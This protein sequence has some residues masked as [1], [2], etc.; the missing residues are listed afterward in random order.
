[1]S[2]CHLKV[3]KTR[4]IYKVHPP[5]LPPIAAP[6]I[7]TNAFLGRRHIHIITVIQHHQLAITEERF[8]WIVVR[9]ALGQAHPMQPQ[10]VP[11]PPGLTRLAWMSRGLIQG[12]PYLLVGIPTTHLA[13]E[14]TDILRTFAR[15]VRPTTAATA[16]VVDQ[17]QIE[18]PA[19]CLRRG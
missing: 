19:C 7:G 10:C 17:E 4:Q 18:S 14:L 13:H 15:K 1:M 9:A 6:Q 2:I 16:N 8:H 3:M 12:D 5:V 11:L